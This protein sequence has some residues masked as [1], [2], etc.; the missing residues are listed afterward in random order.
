MVEFNQLAIYFLFTCSPVLFSF[1]FVQREI[2]RHNANSTRNMEEHTD[3][4]HIRFTFD[5]FHPDTFVAI[6]SCEQWKNLHD[7]YRRDRN[8]LLAQSSCCQQ[9][10]TDVLLDRQTR[11]SSVHVFNTKV[12]PFESH[13]TRFGGSIDAIDQR[14]HV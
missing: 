4:R 9:P 7:D 8:N 11:H 10:L 1:F 2:V 13:S 3:G 5:A 6:L 14:R 12:N